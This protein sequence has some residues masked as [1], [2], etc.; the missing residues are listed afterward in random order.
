MARTGQADTEAVREGGAGDRP[1]P[2]DLLELH[3]ADLAHG[4]AGVARRDGYVVFVEGGLPGD[5]VRAEVTKARRDYANA[6]A[7]EVLEPSPD[8]VPP[9]CD[10]DG[11]QCP[12][13]PW[14]TLRYERQLEHKQRQV[15]DALARLGRLSEYSLEPIV[16][17]EQI[18]R[19]RNKM[20]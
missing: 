13:S 18:W 4:G 14:Q 10:H 11:E 1:R 20:E 15:G 6:R 7:V 16:A 19:Y 9:R 8:R 2:G 12:G 17:A 3:V 5:T